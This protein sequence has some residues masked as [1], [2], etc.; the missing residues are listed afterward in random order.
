M[1]N[2]TRVRTRERR[3]ANLAAVAPLFGRIK[4]ATGRNHRAPTMLLVVSEKSRA[5][6]NDRNDTCQVLDAALGDGQLSSEEHRQ[7][8]SFATKATTLGELHSLVS[9][10]QVRPAA[11]AG[12]S[13][14]SPISKRRV[15]LGLAALMVV[16]AGVE[17]VW[18]YGKDSPSTPPTAQ[19][20]SSPSVAISVSSPPP[21]TTVAPP[22]L[23]T[24]SG[25]TGVFAQMRTQFGDTLGYQLNVY[26]EK[27]VVLR[28]DTANAHVVV[29]WILRDGNWTNLGPSS[30]AFSGSGV[31]DLSKFD[32]QAIMG[33]L[34]DAPQTLQLYD[35]PQTFLAIESRKDG[36]LYINV[37]VSDN[38][39]RS[40]SVVV[41]ADGTVT[42]IDRPRR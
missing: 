21:S 17:L 14:P 2:S 29:Q 42:E 32:V 34:H 7:R 15:L 13:V 35:A 22:Q 41:A 39:R 28:P 26:E 18:V 33:V 37:H 9:D 6:D 11:A 3:S 38:T 25:L 27:V 19:P 31:G 12:T 40:G 20:T 10:L 16:A 1:N 5:T 36:T 4:L 30:G 24:L 23:L 8:V